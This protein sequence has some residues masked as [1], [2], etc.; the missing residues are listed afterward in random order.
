MNVPWT[1]A[2]EVSAALHP[3]LGFEGGRLIASL[4]AADLC[5]EQLSKVVSSDRNGFVTESCTPADL[6][7]VWQR[8]C[9]V[10]ADLVAGK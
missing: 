5:C 4:A 6:A 7:A 2:D 1:M 9:S 8:E 10:L 3:L